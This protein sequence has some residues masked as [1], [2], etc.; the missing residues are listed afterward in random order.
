MNKYTGKAEF[1]LLMTALLAILLMSVVPVLIKWIDANEITIGIVRL[2]IGA[3]GLGLLIQIKNRWVTISRQQRNW[4]F[5]LGSVF[6]VHWYSYFL[7]IK[8]TD[9]SL[10]AIG[11]STFGIHLLF[12]NLLFKQEIFSRIDLLAVGVCILGIILAAPT[13]ALEP[14][15]WL[16]FGISV[17]SGFLYACLPLINKQIVEIPTQIRAFFQFGIALL[18][19]LLFIPYATFELSTRS[20][21]G[22]IMLGVF[23]TLIAHTLWLKVSTELP[24]NLTA[25]VYYGY[26]P[27]SLGLSYLLLDESLHPNKLVGAGLIIVANILVVLSHKSIKASA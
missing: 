22:L 20:W 17:I 19:F 24:A 21:Q 6:A 18:I 27:I 26:V 23:S 4:L 7:S 13:F 3:L 11:V 2:F 10:A 15:K 9:A 1:N 5:L 14:Q 8:M 25:V 12:L 16:G